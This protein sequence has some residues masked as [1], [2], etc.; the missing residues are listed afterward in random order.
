MTERQ[1]SSP[2]PSGN[3]EEAYRI[4]I[5]NRV[6]GILATRNLTLYKASALTR[7]NHPGQP[8]YHVPRNLYFQLRCATWSPTIQQLVAFKQ[9]SGYRLVDWLGVFGF[10]LDDISGLQIRLRQPRTVLLDSTIYDPHARIPWFRD[11][12]TGVLAPPIAPLGQLLERAGSQPMGSLTTKG[13]SSYLYAKIGQQDGYAFP[14][15]APGSIV[16]V[17]SR[18]TGRPPRKSNG[19]TSN[20]IFLV[21]HSRGLCC[22]RLHFGT[23]NRITLRATELPFANVALQLGS[24]ARILGVVDMEVRPLSNHKRPACPRCAEPEVSPDLTR[25]WTPASLDQGSTAKDPGV[26]IRHARQR[27][28]LS[29]RQ[30]SEMSGEIARAFAD[31]RYFASPG[32]LSEYEAASTP[33][34]HI[35]KL[36]TLSIVYALRFSELLDWFGL[37]Q[38]ETSMA[39]IPAEC[40]ARHTKSPAKKSGPIIRGK[41]LVGGFHGN[42]LDRLGELPLFLRGSLAFL[43]GLED[44]SLRDV[45]W[46]GG[47]QEAMHPLLG[48]ALF[49]ILDR[50]K[51]RPHIFPRKSAWEQPVYLLTKRDGSYLMASCAMENGA[52]VLHPYTDKF[53]PPQRFQKSADAE[54]VG[55]IVTVVRSLPSST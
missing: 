43:S 39:A 51:R 22:C 29:L 32:S 34:R 21:E 2:L 23:K 3:R 20:A 41:K 54:V 27:A 17:D 8:R 45:C 47:Q 16:R 10:Q 55:Q 44:I 1:C 49:V 9:L 33:P 42:T 28:G 19:E 31:R 24:E 38:D 18:L 46:V 52:I 25:L 4:A 48:G 50:R 6:R 26:Q 35:H 40:M 11:R 30:A 7:A 13:Q 12:S 53:I 5:A 36:L 15:L 37:G 14:D